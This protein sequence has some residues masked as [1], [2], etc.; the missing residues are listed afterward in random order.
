MAVSSTS[1]ASASATTTSS[2]APDRVGI[3]KRIRNQLSKLPSEIQNCITR[4]K[5]LFRPGEKDIPPVVVRLPEYGGSNHEPENFFRDIELFVKIKSPNGM[6]DQSIGTW[7]AKFDFGFD[8]GRNAPPCIL[9]NRSIPLKYLPE[10]PVTLYEDPENPP[11][12]IYNADGTTMKLYGELDAKWAIRG[13]TK[14]YE[15]QKLFPTGHKFIESRCFLI[16]EESKLSLVQQKAPALQKQ[17][18]D[19]KR[20]QKKIQE[21][22]SAADKEKRKTAKAGKKK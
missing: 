10:G 18:R 13:V 8:E 21:Q 12:R 6:R 15:N 7:P 22:K 17:R 1:G 4:L 5:R 19:E 16:S 14:E 2:I 3:R 20:E 9:L 11:V